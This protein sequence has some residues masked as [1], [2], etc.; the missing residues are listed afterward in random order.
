LRVLFLFVF[1]AAS[2]PAQT[3]SEMDELLG[4]RAASFAQ[5]A[6][7]ALAAAGL[8]SEDGPPEAAFTLA[9]G[10]GWLPEE[11]RAE[12]PIP[13]G[14]LCFLI[15]NAFG[16]E[17]SF[18]YGLFPG[19]RHA[20]REFGYRGFIPGRRD[21]ALPVS[22]EDLLWILAMAASHTGMDQGEGQKV[23]TPAPAI[24]EEAPAPETVAG[25]EEL[26]GIIRAE[27]EEHQAEDTGV[28]V[29]EEGVVISLNNI[30]FTADSVELTENEKLKLREIAAIIARHPGR[31]ILVAGHTAMAGSAGGRL[32]VSRERARAVADYLVS[33]EARKEGEITVR[34]YGAQYPLGDNATPAGQALNRRVE[35]TLMDGGRQ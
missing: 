14:D 28:R 22:G 10:R 1:A 9:G 13:T 8:T 32:R 19:P 5:A 17:G 18:L 16:M 30:R 27:L 7:F 29:S 24:Q 12:E 11:A 35:I 3:A 15:M 6:R 31:H 34:G 20:F 23:F 33:L 25:R 26:A 4:A 21:P 2:L